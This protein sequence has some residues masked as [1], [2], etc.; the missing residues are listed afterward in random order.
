MRTRIAKRNEG[1]IYVPAYSINN[2]GGNVR[3]YE[4]MNRPVRTF[5]DVVREWMQA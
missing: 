1:A 5:G 3:R 4:V 2:A